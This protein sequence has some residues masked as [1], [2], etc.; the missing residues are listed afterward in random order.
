MLTLSEEIS[1]TL[2]KRIQRAFLA[3]R[4]VSRELKKILKDQ[5]FGDP[6]T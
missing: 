3:S 1:S 5:G 6:L 2:L 4:H